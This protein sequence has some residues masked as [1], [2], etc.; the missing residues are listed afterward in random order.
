MNGSS[1][2]KIGE[3]KLNAQLRVSDTLVGSVEWLPQAEKPKPGQLHQ[4]RLIAKAR[5]GVKISL[6]ETLKGV[7]NEESPLLNEVEHRVLYAVRRGLQIALAVQQEY[8]VIVG[9]DQMGDPSRMSNDKRTELQEKLRSASAIALFVLASYVQHQLAGATDEKSHAE[10]ITLPE[11]AFGEPVSSLK[12]ALFY[13]ALNLKHPKVDNDMALVATAALYFEKVFAEIET[14]QETFR[15]LEGYNTITFGVDGTDFTIDGFNRHETGAASI[16]FKRTEMKD[17]VGNADAKHFARRL[18]HRMLCYNF[19]TMSNI[20][21]ELGGFPTFWMGF[22]KPGTGKSMLIAAIATMLKDYSTHMNVPF[23]FHPLPDNI[24]DSYQGNSAKNMLA[25]FKSIHVTD[26]LVFAPIDDGENIL[27][28]R[29]RQGVSEGVRGAIGVLLRMTESAYSV[30]HG[31]ATIGVFTNLPEQI[32][33]AVR[34]RIQGR[35][36]IDGAKSVEDALDQSELWWRKF[37]DQPGFVNLS[38]P[39]WYL[40]QNAQAELKSFAEAA[41][42]RDIPEHSAVKDIYEAVAKEHDPASHEFF[43]RLYVAITERFQAFSSRDIRNVQSAVDSRIMDFD[44]PEEWFE[45]PEVF[46]LQTYEH[47]RDM[48]LELRKANM[49]GLHFG[50]ILRQET[51]RYLDSYAEIA[52]AQFDRDVEERVKR[53]R[54][55][56]EV[57]RRLQL[58]V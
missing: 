40:Y 18:V 6:T 57:E 24:I 7:R 52:D 16:E 45:N 29:T 44:L 14:R 8:R 12:C 39:D 41:Q 23:L 19:S 3:D 35:M 28:E 13:L 47:Q 4:A 5:Q 22:G 51:V 49:K 21:V 9:V 56:Q 48:V 55:E 17:I 15:Y 2:T 31:N 42:T 53:I 37:K 50:D 33:A 43:A 30:N 32:D 11:L 54:V 1:L 26:K 10:H 58:A 25:W 36:V 20:F 38:D 34:S 27:E 46:S